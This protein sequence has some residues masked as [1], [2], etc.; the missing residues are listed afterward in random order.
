MRLVQTWRW[1]RITCCAWVLQAFSAI[2]FAQV[3]SACKGP[4][5]LEK[6]IASQ[7]SAG[8]YDA[9]G[10]YFGQR[11][12]LSCALAAFEAAVHQDPKSWEARFNLSLA[13]LQKHD[14]TRAARE[15]RVA[16]GIK[17][18]DP[19]GHIA[20]GQA[21]LGGLAKALIA[22]KRYSAAI[23]YLKDGPPDPVLQDDLAVAYSSNG[24]VAEAVKLL[25][26]LVQ[27][28]PSSAER[29]ARLGLAYTQDS[30]FRQAVDE[31]R[32]AL[33]LDSSNDATRRSY[34]KA[35]IVLAEFQ[36]ALPE[37]QNYFRRKPHDFDALYLM[38]VVDRGLGKYAA[39]E[40]LLRQ[41]IALH[42]NDYDTLYNLG[43]VLA[44]LGRP[45]EALVH[46][47]KA[48][49]LNAASSEARFQLAAVL[50]S[51]GQEQRAREELEGLQ[52]KKQ[53]SVKE[54]VAGTK[55]NQAN[56]Y[57]Q[58]G[59][60]QRAADLYREA[61]GQNPENARTYYDMALALDQLGKTAEEH[62]ALKKAISLDSN[63]ARAHNQ[64]GLLCLQAGQQAEAE[65]ELKAAIALDLGYAE[66][67]NNLGVLYGQQGKN[68][69][70]E[71]LFRLA[72]ENNPQ[73]MQ[74]FINLGLILAGES[75][76]PEAEQP[77][78]KSFL[79]L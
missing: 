9:L 54:D 42:S 70:A 4:A 68:N 77:I 27:Q 76:F 5:E 47:E 8:V 37:I 16:T 14:P 23:A 43:F 52:E 21:A 41:A 39:A 30:Q 59:E 35:L 7:P 22:Q 25:A 2:L 28:N 73:Y 48:V 10:A 55:V 60:Y 24:D 44:K 3:P 65:T 72:T 32:A 45:Q 61:L 49:Q 53:Q 79:M 46:L 12:Q 29:H 1:A 19:L 13:L 51:L 33:Q 36:T 26:Q 69:E 20:L 58:A 66:A 57:F 74:A 64:L 67:Q 15:L 34:V 63:L 78:R 40:D 17:P 31:F 56:E 71:K 50:R 62:E 18:D 38:G 6:V 75:R 11:Q